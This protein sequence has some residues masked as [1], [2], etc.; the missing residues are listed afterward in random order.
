MSKHRLCVAL[1]VVLA[2]FSASAAAQASA[3]PT[4]TVVKVPFRV[5]AAAKA[6]IAACVG[7]QVV[8]TDGLFN[9]VFHRSADGT[10]FVFHRNVID[11]V[12]IGTVTGTTYRATGHIQAVDNLL[13]SGGETFTFEL[14]LNVVGAGGAAHFTAH[15]VE[16]L[17]I[18]PD[19]DLVSDVEI[20]GIRCT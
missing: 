6:D 15:A 9:V 10:H 5:S 17:T 11:G 16:H 13:L 18:T 14:T 2:A 19:G 12:G 7:E 8:F 4:T 3:G 20:D 1:F